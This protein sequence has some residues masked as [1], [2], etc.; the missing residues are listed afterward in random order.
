MEFANIEGYRSHHTLRSSGRSG[1]VSIFCE[2][3]FKATKVD[4]LSCSN[5]NIETCCVC[6]NVESECIYV[7]AVYRPVNGSLSEFIELVYEKLQDRC[8]RGRKVIL[9]GDLNLDLTDTSNVHTNDFIYN[10]RALHF[11][12]TILSPTRFSNTDYYIRPSLLDHIWVNFF[13]EVHSGIVWADLTDHCPVFLRMLS[14]SV[15]IST[16]VNVSFR[17]HSQKF[18]EK[19]HRALADV[20]W[21]EVLIGNLDESFNKFSIFL[22]GLYCKTFPRLSKK[23]SKKRMNNPWLT[24][25][26]LRSIKTKS[27]YFKLYK[28]GVISK[29]TNNSYRNAVNRLIRIAKKNYFLNT[30]ENVGNN[31]RSTWKNIRNIMGNKRDKTSYSL[32]IDNEE[33]SDPVRVSEQFNLFF[34]TVASRLEENIPASDLSPLSYVRNV[35]PNSFFLSPISTEEC[36]DIIG[37]LRNTKGKHDELPI[38]LWKRFKLLLAIPLSVLINKAFVTGEFPSCLKCATVIPI[39]KSGNEADINNFRPISILPTLSKI[40]EKSITDRIIKYSNRYSLLAPEQF[41]FQ[42][43]LSTVDAVSK[44]IEYVYDALN[45]RETTI[46]VFIDMKKAFDTINHTILLG[47]LKIY[48]IRDVPLRL[49]CSYLSDRLQHVKIENSFSSNR[50]VTC[51]IPQGSCLGPLLFFILH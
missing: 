43:G 50:R 20:R 10:M 40:L 47:K 39:H 36:S 37:N 27:N 28:Q 41:G 51:G 32:L 46:S 25:G 6:L 17:D 7:L 3:V 49:L 38:W 4:S 21:D 11:L 33:V 35:H 8:L 13:S 31:I 42:S 22:N 48:G 45:R 16:E 1:G 14:P 12:P 24:S 5:A 26:I 18:V 23:L 15:N 9:A 34:S 2:N 19:F 29:A 30:F 44:F